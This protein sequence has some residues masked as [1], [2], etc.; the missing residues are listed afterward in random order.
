M[1]NIYSVKR[2]EQISEVD[3]DS[4]FAP[5][6][7]LASVSGTVTT[8]NGV[9]SVT[10]V[11]AGRVGISFNNNFVNTS[12]AAFVCNRSLSAVSFR[13]ENQDTTNLAVGRSDF[14]NKVASVLTD[15][16]VWNIAIIGTQL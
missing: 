2:G 11:G 16:T 12:Y 3:L 8:S 13:Q 9:S 10:D 14:T 1:T 5:V 6:W 4:L 7:C 15:P